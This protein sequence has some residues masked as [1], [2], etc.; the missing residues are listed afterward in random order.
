MSAA[1]QILDFEQP[2]AEIERQ[3]S[4]LET[5]PDAA[6][7]ADEIR[8]LQETRNSLLNKTYGNLTPWQ[9]VRVARHPQRPQTLDYVQM[10]CR[11]WC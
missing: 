9:T 2:I 8:T 7:I 11:D 5:R 1:V 6:A 3:I 10:I 4:A